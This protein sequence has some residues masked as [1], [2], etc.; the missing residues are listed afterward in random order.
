MEAGVGGEDGFGVERVVAVPV[1]DLRAGA[2]ENRQQ[3]VQVPGREF[4][5]SHDVGTPVG[6]E[7]I[8]VA[9]APGAEEARAVEQGVPVF[10]RVLGFAVD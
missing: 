4:R 10:V 7:Q 5:V 1:G 9:I 3:R 6:D 2:P 8:A